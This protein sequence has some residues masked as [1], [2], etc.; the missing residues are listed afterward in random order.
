LIFGAI[1][2]QRK[3]GFRCARRR[4]TFARETAQNKH[5]QKKQAQDQKMI[6]VILTMII[7]SDLFFDK[8]G[9]ESICRSDEIRDLFPFRYPFLFCAC[10]PRA[11]PKIK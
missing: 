5:R 1:I 9:C 7:K 6:A 4:I 11:N 10:A 2:F 3:R 8:R